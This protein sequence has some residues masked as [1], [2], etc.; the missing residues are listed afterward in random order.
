MAK[1]TAMVPVGESLEGMVM[2]DHVDDRVKT[3]TKS[4]G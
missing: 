2:P 4:T 1:W 3:M